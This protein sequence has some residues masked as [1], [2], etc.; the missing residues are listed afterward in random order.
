MD[1]VFP[2]TKQH[3]EEIRAPRTAVSN[4][5][6]IDLAI[7]RLIDVRNL[8]IMVGLPRLAFAADACHRNAAASQANPNRAAADLPAMATSLARELRRAEA[9]WI[10]VLPTYALQPPTHATRPPGMPS[11][12]EPSAGIFADDSEFKLHA[13]VAVRRRPAT[14]H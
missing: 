10:A 8:A 1:A 7:E 5:S 3:I 12:P 14:L 9:E 2:V 13:A 4:R 6:A 11:G